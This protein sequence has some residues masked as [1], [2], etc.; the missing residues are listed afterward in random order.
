[1][2]TKGKT[3]H[4]LKRKAEREFKPE[5]V[6]EILRIEKKGKFRKIKSLDDLTEIA[7]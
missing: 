2:K 1:M 7:R 3:K 4:K 6:A 5:F